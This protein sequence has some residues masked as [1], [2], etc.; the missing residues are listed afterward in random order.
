MANKYYTVQNG[1]RNCHWCWKNLVGHRYTHARDALQAAKMLNDK[2]KEAHGSAYIEE[3]TIF[4]F[5]LYKKRTVFSL[6]ELAQ[7]CHL[8]LQDL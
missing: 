2:C 8:R 6:A 1:R 7:H 5:G 3:W 4:L